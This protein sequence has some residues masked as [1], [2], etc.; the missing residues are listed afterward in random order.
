MAQSEAQ[1]SYASQFVTTVLVAVVG[2]ILPELPLFQEIKKKASE[3]NSKV[4][5]VVLLVLVGIIF[6][7]EQ[8]HLASLVDSI[9]SPILSLVTGLIFGISSAGGSGWRGFRCVFYS[10]FS[11]MMFL[12]RSFAGYRTYIA[13]A[14]IIIGLVR[15]QYR[16]QDFAAKAELIALVV[17]LRIL[18][19]LCAFFAIMIVG[20]K[21]W[22]TVFH[23]IDV[24]M[25]VLSRFIVA[26]CV[27]IILV[28]IIIGLIADRYGLVE[29][30]AKR[31]RAARKAAKATRLDIKPRRKLVQE[32][33]TK[34]SHDAA[35]QTS[36]NVKHR[37]EIRREEQ[38]KSR[39]DNSLEA[40]LQP[41]A[42]VK[43]RNELRREEQTKSCV[44]E[45]PV[46]ALQTSAKVKDR[47]ETRS[48]EQTKSCL[49]DSHEAVL[50]AGAKVKDRSERKGKREKATKLLLEHSHEAGLQASA[51]VKDRKTLIPETWRTYSHRWSCAMGGHFAVDTLRNG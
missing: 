7:H 34:I 16:F 36:A 47:N 29:A 15:D 6:M 38:T 45:P 12:W 1:T 37:H 3:G 50:Q 33:E 42:K 5:V 9:L 46:A 17:D 32:E 13:L 49:E 20:P 43:D 41:T 28:L 21:S 35:P 18:V 39:V 25:T 31:L 27:H 51:K 11:S 48:D 2:S 14:L 8:G 24:C 22:R 44:E 4:Q 10:V 40:V 26:Y 30:R 23:C 19:K